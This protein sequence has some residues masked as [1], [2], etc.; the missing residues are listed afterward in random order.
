MRE[1]V[2]AA[3]LGGVGPDHVQARVA[4]V[5][6]WTCR[7]VSGDD[8]AG[9]TLEGSPAN[10]NSGEPFDPC[11]AARV[12]RSPRELKGEPSDGG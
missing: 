4:Y 2:E 7:V 12:M 3:L 9:V 6:C 10:R 1:S 11:L 8:R 5:G